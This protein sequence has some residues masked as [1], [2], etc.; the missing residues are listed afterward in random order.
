MSSQPLRA[1]TDTSKSPSDESENI[2]LT[3]FALQSPLSGNRNFSA[4]SPSREDQ[5]QYIQPDILQGPNGRAVSEIQARDNVAGQSFME[6]LHRSDGGND[7]TLLE[8]NG[9]DDSLTRSE[10]HETSQDSYEDVPAATPMGYAEDMA[11]QAST[12]DSESKDILLCDSFT[13][14]RANDPRI[15]EFLK[16][17]PKDLLETALKAEAV[18]DSIPKA[19]HECTECHKP[20][21]RPCEL[22]C[23]ITAPL[24]M[25]KLTQR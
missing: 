5:M 7:T 25:L 2:S 9:M 13:D 8:T 6:D 3:G 14:L 23:V 19:Q 12:S 1:L 21:R 15:L 10:T 11:P 18:G 4:S 24:P 20:F 16:S 17:I 22:K